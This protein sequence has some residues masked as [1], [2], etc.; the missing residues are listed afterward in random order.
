MRS[1]LVATLLLGCAT[2]PPRQETAAAPAPVK[3]AVTPDADYRQQPP[4]P[5][6]PVEFKAPVPKQLTLKNGLPAF[7]V[8]RHEVPLVSLVVA[9]RSGAE[10]EPRGKAGLSSMALE[11]LGEGTPT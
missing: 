10:T 2:T 8:E 6:A 1:L 9:V 4:A 7:L 11:L 5:G 3:P